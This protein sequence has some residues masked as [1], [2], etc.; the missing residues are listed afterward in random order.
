MALLLGGAVLA[1]GSLSVS[2]WGEYEGGDAVVVLGPPALVVGALVG[3][4]LGGLLVDK[5]R[6][7]PP[8]ARGTRR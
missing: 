8:S 3:A 7:L 2:Q 5:R 1:L 4:W 6:Q